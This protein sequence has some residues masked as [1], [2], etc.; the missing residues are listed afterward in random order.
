MAHQRDRLQSALSNVQ[1]V[2]DAAKRFPWRP[3]PRTRV[4]CS[5]LL[6]V[7]QHA[8]AAVTHACTV[9]TAVHALATCR[10]L[11]DDE[12]ECRVTDTL[13]SA[14]SA[15][16]LS[17]IRGDTLSECV[18]RG[19]V[20][21]AR[22]VLEYFSRQP[23][24]AQQAMP[25]ADAARH[26]TQAANML[27]AMWV[28]A[29]TTQRQHVGR[30]FAASLWSYTTNCS[31]VVDFVR[32]HG[33]DVSA[34]MLPSA[35]SPHVMT[36]LSAALARYAPWTLSELRA[37]LE[38]GADPCEMH[39][40]VNLLAVRMDLDR[41]VMPHRYALVRNELRAHRFLL[42]EDRRVRVRDVTKGRRWPAVFWW[43][44]RC[45]GSVYYSL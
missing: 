25:W 21:R 20:D 9:G 38:A 16:L 19:T 15:P 18:A 42:L 24:F 41:W 39:D 40:G 8:E 36:P 29:N 43:A 17:D 4:F 34:P 45:T 14:L 22:I 33:G 1:V 7:L 31:V 44:L 35:T 13:R 5:A 26:P 23:K 11:D 10:P 3:L 32:T 37:L 30:I 28:A 6:E 27:D 2:E 12:E